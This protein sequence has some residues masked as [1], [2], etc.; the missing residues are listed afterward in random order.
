MQ[1][2]ICDRHA[3]SQQSLHKLHL[4]ASSLIYKYKS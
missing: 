4:V 3:A 2:A 1:R